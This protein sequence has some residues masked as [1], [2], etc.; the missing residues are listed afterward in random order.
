MW[1]KLQLKTNS[2]VILNQPECFN[3]FAAEIANSHTVH[4]SLLKKAKE[5]DWYLTFVTAKSQVTPL[6]KHLSTLSAVDPVVWM[7]YP[8][9]S[10]KLYDK[11]TADI[12]RD[13]G[14]DELT[15][16]DF[17]PVSAVS[18][19][20]DWSA[21]RFRKVQNITE[22]NRKSANTETGKARVA[23]ATKAKN[24]VSGCGS[25]GMNGKKRAVD[26]DSV[27]VIA[28]KKV[29]SAAPAS[30]AAVTKKSTHTKK[31]KK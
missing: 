1:K 15:A 3:T 14:W 5:C 11:K 29:K 20:D 2:L 4:S 17:E 26:D 9:M 23:A 6:A 10:S 16:A 22:M 24:G 7:A 27:D 18:I 8:K 25:S 13:K 21:L 28:P 30:A 31:E 12:S 19:D